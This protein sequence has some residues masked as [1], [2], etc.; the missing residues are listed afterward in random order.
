[1]VCH[2]D[3]VLVARISLRSSVPLGARD[4]WRRCRNAAF[5]GVIAHRDTRAWLDLL[6]LPSLVRPS[7]SRGGTSRT[8]RSTNETRRRRQDWLNV[9]W[10]PPKRTPGRVPPKGQTSSP[11]QSIELDDRTASRVQTLISEGALRRACTA[12]TCEP[13]MVPSPEVV[14]ELSSRHPGPAEAHQEASDQ[15]GDVGPGVV[16]VIDSDMVRKA[17]SSF[18]PISGAGQSG[19]RPSHL[20]EAEVIKLMLRGEIPED[21]RPWICG[22]SLMALR[23]P[24]ASLRLVKV[25]VELMG[26]SVRSILELTQVGVQ[27]KAGCEAIIH[28]TSQWTKTFCDDPDRVLVLV[29]LYNAL[30]VFREEPCSQPIRVSEAQ[31]PGELDYKAFFLDDEAIA[32]KAH[33]VQLFLDTL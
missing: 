2:L 9:L 25:A 32:G 30:I 13:P 31:Y 14:E 16:P 27:T 4:P 18:A 7:P 3:Q 11:E 5:A 8:R 15:L 1:M 22:A 12:L 21:I 33:A 20:Q 6:I 28:T 17:L 29:D 10:N 24:N 26:S 23:K 19:L